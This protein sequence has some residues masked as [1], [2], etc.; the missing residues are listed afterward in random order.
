MGRFEQ[1]WCDTC[2]T[3]DVTLSSSAIGVSVGIITQY[4]DPI[5]HFNLCGVCRAEFDKKAIETV[6]M[7][8]KLFNRMVV[9]VVDVDVKLKRRKWSES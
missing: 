3:K 6:A 4:L 9:D 7:F 5:A 8:E 2:G 1:S